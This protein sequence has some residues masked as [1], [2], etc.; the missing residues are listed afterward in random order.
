MATG[1]YDE[2]IRL[3]EII[4][5]ARD[6]LTE[7]ARYPAERDDPQYTARRVGE[8]E[9]MIKMLADSAE[10]VAQARFP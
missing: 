7:D 2:R 10:I 3:G 8:L 1:A 9:A 4:A 6:M 5:D